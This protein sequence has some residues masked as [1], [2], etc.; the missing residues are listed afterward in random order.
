MRYDRGVAAAVVVVERQVECRSAVDPLWRVLTD[1]SYLNRLTGEAPRQISTIEGGD[2]ARYRI[3]TKAGGFWVEWEEWPFEWL[4]QQR[5]RVFRKFR[6][7]P[8]ASVD[9]VLTFAALPEGGARIG[10]KLELVPKVRWLAWMVRLGTRRA[11]DAL[12]LSVR[13]IDEA[14]ARRAPLPVPAKA[15]PPEGLAGL[16][17]AQRELRAQ[18]GSPELVDRL[19]DWVRAARD[20]ELAR[21]RPFALADEWSVDRRAM[22]TTCLQAVRS[23]LLELRWEVICPSCRVGTEVLSSLAAVKEHAQCHLCEIAFGLDLD[24]ALEAT[25]APTPAVRKLDVG[26]YCVGGPARTPH[27]LAQALLPARGRATLTAPDVPGRYR[28]FVRGG[29][30]IALEV[31]AEGPA[32][33]TV[34]TGASAPQRLRAGGAVTVESAHADDRHVKLE[35][36]A[37]DSQAATAREVSL[38]PGF[39]RDFSSEVLRPDLA[40]KVSSVTLFFSDLTAS[41]QLYSDVGDA[42]ALRLVH[43]HFDVVLGVVERHGGTLIKTIGDAVMAAFVDDLA[44]VAASLEMLQAFEKFRRE[45]PN[46]SRT[47]LKLGVFRGPSYLVTA[48]GV[49]DYF[50]QTVNIA[51]RLQAQAASGELVIEAALADLAVQEGRLPA[52]AVRERY[53]ASLKG[54]TQEIEV[55]RVVAV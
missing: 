39:R 18:A 14:L 32:A 52:A 2:G 48:N 6:A 3:K 11:A 34:P 4:H 53:R 38:V 28:L 29:E 13:A 44:A 43:D 41:T 31:G 49:L 10:I 20:E 15:K 35:R 27:V 1:T 51:A 50:G 9:T 7:G 40:L 16:D 19:C 54:V 37:H 22:L 42:A 46:G 33:L 55:A 47:H 24:E 25:F 5:F 17:R 12:A 23:G 45:V 26:Q 36:V 30:A 21:I 8:V